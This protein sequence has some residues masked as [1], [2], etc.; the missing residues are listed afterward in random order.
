M[1]L[2]VRRARDIAEFQQFRALQIEYEES[3][4]PDLRHSLPDLPGLRTTYVGPN[5]AFLA[6]IDQD[7]SGCMAVTALDASTSVLKR[8]YVTPAYR[9]LGIA[10]ALIDV[11]TSFSRNQ[12]HDRI[13][14]DTDRERLPAAYRLYLSLG[15]EK[16]EPYG[17]VDYA[18]PT[19]MEL[20]L[21]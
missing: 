15:F 16:C 13:V 6:S 8:L 20:R 10:R 7:A 11:A 19:Y 4:P 1:A 5:A 2:D 3:L 12:H 14:L 9:G 18:S 17:P 21:R